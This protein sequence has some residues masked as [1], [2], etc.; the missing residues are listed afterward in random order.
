[1]EPDETIAYFYSLV[2]G[3]ASTWPTSLPKSDYKNYTQLLEKFK[4]TN[5]NPKFAI[6]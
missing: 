3:P 1:M 2:S 6:R 4:T 5:K